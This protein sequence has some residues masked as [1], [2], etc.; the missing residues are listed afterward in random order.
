MVLNRQWIYV[1]RPQ[2]LVGP[3]HYRVVSQPLA[4]GDQIVVEIR[5]WSVDPYMRIQQ[6][7]QHTWEEPHALNTVQQGDAIGQVIS[8]PHNE[9]R[10]KIG[11][12]VQGYWG[13]QTHVALPPSE[14]VVWDPSMPPTSALGVLGMPG[15]TA[16]FGL[17]EGGK[18][19]AGETLL[20]SG[21][22]GAV[23]SLVAQF[24]KKL[25][26]KVVGI[27]GGSEKGRFLVEDLGLDAAIDYKSGLGPVLD[28]ALALA[29][30][31]GIDVYFDNVGGPISDQVIPRLNVGGRMVV[32]GQISQYNGQ[33]D[34][35]ELGP[36]LLHHILYKR[37]TIQG[38][39]A[40]DFKDRMPELFAQVGPWVRNR[41]IQVAETI[42]QGFERL[43]EALSALFSGKNTGKLIVQ[44]Y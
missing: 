24:G 37:A 20:V 13:W 3:E 44:A 36:R 14:V 6:A 31:N 18:P 21:A 19:K 2:G 11:D 12:W 16:W 26:L 34:Q 33:L 8:V 4:V 38:I 22:A 32:C 35:P 1:E 23:G 39:L 17:L 7:E 43:P 25:G 10:I 42:I 9:S 5:Y 28:E 41:E 40:R 15:R 30:P 29:C 27:A